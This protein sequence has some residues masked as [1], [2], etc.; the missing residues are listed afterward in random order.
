MMNKQTA[1][2]I[3]KTDTDNFAAAFRYAIESGGITFNMT[4]F[5]GWQDDC[6]CASC[7]SQRIVFDFLWPAGRN[8]EHLDLGE[9][10]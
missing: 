1:I 3:L 5:R 4:N 6:N 7:R 8:D 2:Q 10:E 9:A